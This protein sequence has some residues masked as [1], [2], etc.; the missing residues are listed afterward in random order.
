[1]KGTRTCCMEPRPTAVT[2]RVIARRGTY[3]PADLDLEPFPFGA[4]EDRHLIN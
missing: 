1:M 4:Y 2:V 3:I